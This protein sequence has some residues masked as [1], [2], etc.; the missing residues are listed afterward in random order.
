[1]KDDFVI[2]VA[3]CFFFKETK[4]D[5]NTESHKEYKNSSWKSQLQECQNGVAIC[6]LKS[7]MER[8]IYF[9]KVARF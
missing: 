4:M 9:P 2:L 5:Y 6:F 3:I 7:T 8:V 1:L